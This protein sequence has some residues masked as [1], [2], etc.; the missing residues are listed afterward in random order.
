MG[1]KHMEYIKLGRT[2]QE[3]PKIGFGTARYNGGAGVLP[4]AA[5]LGAW[6]VD[7]AEAYNVHGDEPGHAESLVG[8][9]IDPVRDQMFI[10]TK[11]SPANFRYEDVLAHADASRKRLQTDVIDLYQLH[12]PKSEVPI[13]ETMRAMEE[14]VSRGEVRFIGVSN[15]SVNQMKAA[16]DALHSNPLV[17][18]QL[19]YHL[20][21]REIEAEVLPY[22]QEQGITVIAYSPLAI[23]ALPA[24]DRGAQLREVAESAGRSWAQVMLNWVVGHERVMAIPKTDRRERVQELVESVGW[25]LRSEQR[26]TL[27]GLG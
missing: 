3:I 18:N 4:R 16:Q 26:A 8:E 1:G 7:T 11:I 24:D 19:K 14:L 27:D 22:C 5:E 17:S 15:F 2:E 25:E 21:A 12:S 10:A 9:E 23:G 20:F 13:S 6:L